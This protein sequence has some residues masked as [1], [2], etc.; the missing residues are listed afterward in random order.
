MSNLQYL[1]RLDF[2]TSPEDSHA[3]SFIS[4]YIGGRK[5][6]VGTVERG[7]AIVCYVGS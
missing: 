4:P 7:D 3:S 1:R 5:E 2:A 6:L